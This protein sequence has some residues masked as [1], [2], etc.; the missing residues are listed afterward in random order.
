MRLEQAN[1]PSEDLPMQLPIREP[2]M[3]VAADGDSQN[4]LSQRT[5]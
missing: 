3:K 1:S 2:P 5:P 4:W